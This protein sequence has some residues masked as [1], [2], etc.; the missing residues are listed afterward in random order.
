VRFTEINAKVIQRF[1]EVR[2]VDTQAGEPTKR[3]RKLADQVFRRFLAPVSLELLDGFAWLIDRPHRMPMARVVSEQI[4]EFAA[5]L[6]Q[7]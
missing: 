5:L 6:H 7:V 3:Y 2:F 1:C 4:G